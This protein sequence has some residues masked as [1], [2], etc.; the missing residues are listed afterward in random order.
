[1]DGR[2]RPLDDDRLAAH[3][4]P[5]AESRREEIAERGLDRGLG[6]AVPVHPQRDFVGSGGPFPGE[7]VRARLGEGEPYVANHSRPLEIGER[8]GLPGFTQRLSRL[9]GSSGA[10]DETRRER[11]PS[12]SHNSRDGDPARGGAQATS[13]NKAARTPRRGA[14]MG[15][16][17]SRPPLF[18][19]AERGA[20]RRERRRRAPLGAIAPFAVT[21]YRPAG[22]RTSPSKR[23]RA[24]SRRAT[25]APPSRATSTADPGVAPSKLIARR[26]ARATVK[27]KV[28]SSVSL[29]ISSAAPPRRPSPSAAPFRWE[30]G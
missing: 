12:S 16:E 1:M 4:G 29:V 19:H 2:N 7:P 9:L 28:T 26:P 24:T 14:P 11:A 21:T 3:L 15:A 25:T 10:V 6:R 13:A 20:T 8:E 27:S 18:E 22:R 30:S 23:L 17:R 5:L